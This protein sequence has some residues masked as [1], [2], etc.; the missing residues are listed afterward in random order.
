MA[1]K[2]TK[3]ATR[4]KSSVPQSLEPVI[5]TACDG[6]SRDPN[7]GKC[8]IYGIFDVVYS[9]SFPMTHKAFTVFGKFKATKGK[10]KLT[11]KFI[12][13]EGESTEIGELEVVIKKPDGFLVLDGQ[14]AGLQFPKAGEYRIALCEGRKA[15]GLPIA[16]MAKKISKQK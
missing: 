8:S 11:I 13:P 5:L 9:D 7:T 12:T 4:K 3:K 2:T 10:H 6:V 1:K 14:I 15:L 16:L